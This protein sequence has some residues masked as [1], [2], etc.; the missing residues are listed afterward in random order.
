MEDYEIWNRIEYLHKFPPLVDFMDLFEDIPHNNPIEILPPEAIPV[1][2]KKLIMISI[3]PIAP[4][5]SLVTL[6]NFLTKNKAL[7]IESATI[8]IKSEFG[9]ALQPQRLNI[10][11]SFL[12]SKTFK[13]HKDYFDHLRRAWVF[14][15]K[16]QY[17]FTA[18]L[19]KIL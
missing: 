8:A 13:T 18:L 19:L 5:I 14:A 2:P 12:N 10:L 16:K 4:S 17:I 11:I 15:V 9:G 7:D 1:H 6:N 3:N